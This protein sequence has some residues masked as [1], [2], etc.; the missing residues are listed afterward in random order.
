[1]VSRHCHGPTP[2]CWS[3]GIFNNFRA[4][5][6]NQTKKNGLISLSEQELVDCDN[7]RNQ[8]FVGY[9]KTLFKTKYRILKN[10]WGAKLGEKGYT[11]KRDR[12]EL[13]R[14][15][16]GPSKNSSSNPARPSDSLKNELTLNNVHYYP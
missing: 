12:V 4:E 1:M 2:L 3:L 7:E 11:R 13:L 6:I 16:G 15:L 10:S 14:R 5:S 9:G 8:G